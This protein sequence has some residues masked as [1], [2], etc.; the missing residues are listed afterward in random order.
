MMPSCVCP[1]GLVVFKDRCVDPLECHSLLHC[2]LY[3]VM[4]RVY[5]LE[6][7]VFS[8]G[9][10]GFEKTTAKHFCPSSHSLQP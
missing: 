1:E 10:V 2:R 7:T 8:D 4:E 3:A 9:V 5:V 6:E